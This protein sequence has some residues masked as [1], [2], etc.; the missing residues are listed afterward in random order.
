[1]TYLQFRNKLVRKVRRTDFTATCDDIHV[2]VNSA[3]HNV[4]SRHNFSGMEASGRFQNALAE[5]DYRFAVPCSFKEIIDLRVLDSD[6]NIRVVLAK[7]V[8]RAKFNR[9][10]VLD[11]VQWAIENYKDTLI[12]ID[13]TGIEGFPLVYSMW[14]D[15]IEVF[16][17]VGAQCAG[18]YL[19]MAFYRYLD[20]DMAGLAGEI[21]TYSDFLFQEQEPLTFNAA[22]MEA[23]LHFKDE[24]MVDKWAGLYEQGLL[25]LYKNEIAKKEAGRAGGCFGD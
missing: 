2:I 11:Q 10:V 12:L 25:S 19:W 21:D 4:Q 24:E 15:A 8:D 5:N 16:P 6:D 1:M 17:K 22:M 14:S 7:E 23:G 18:N 9:L 20:Q 13:L 3:R